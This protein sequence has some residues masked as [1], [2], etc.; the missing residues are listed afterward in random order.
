LVGFHCR[1]SFLQAR[2][3]DNKGYQ[4]VN[5]IHASQVSVKGADRT[6]NG[7]SQEELTQG[8]FTWLLATQF[9]SSCVG[10]SDDVLAG[11]TGVICLQETVSDLETAGLQL[12]YYPKY[13]GGEI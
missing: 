6:E 5:F 13:V 7:I 11:H 9:N 3:G 2:N 10:G 4:L 8:T 1:I 12:V